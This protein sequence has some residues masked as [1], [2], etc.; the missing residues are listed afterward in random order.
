ML[1]YESVRHR[2]LTYNV[3]YIFLLFC[4]TLP[5]LP[6]LP[7]PPQPLPTAAVGV[8]AAALATR[9]LL[10]RRGW[11]A[12][13]RLGGVGGWVGTGRCHRIGYEA[14]NMR[15]AGQDLRHL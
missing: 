1:T 9:L 13:G 2:I 7:L 5:P 15:C 12:G 10:L 6:P 11:R 14:K 4:W 8:V 3:A